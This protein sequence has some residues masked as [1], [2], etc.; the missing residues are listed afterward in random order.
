L[1][2]TRVQLLTKLL[3]LRSFSK[4]LIRYADEAGE[5][6]NYDD[7]EGGVEGE[8]VYIE[9]DGEKEVREVVGRM[10]ALLKEVMQKP[11][12]AKALGE[13]EGKNV[14]VIPDV[15]MQLL[16]LEALGALKGAKSVSRD[17]SAQLFLSRLASWGK[18]GV[19]SMK[20]MRYERERARRGERA[21]RASAIE[22]GERAN[23]ASTKEVAVRP[24][25]KYPQNQLSSD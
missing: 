16:P 3:L 17:F 4:F 12:I 10:D 18:T 8:G 21:R 5:E 6:G 7:A 20:S 1:S 23:E 2:T 14:V 9:D 22:R 11:Q 13:A 24:E 19:G 15:R 25:G